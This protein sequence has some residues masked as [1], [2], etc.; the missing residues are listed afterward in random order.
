[1]TQDGLRRF[2]HG[3]CIGDPRKGKLLRCGGLWFRRSTRTAHAP[4]EL[5]SRG[6]CQSS[7][8]LCTNSSVLLLGRRWFH[9]CVCHLHLKKSEWM[10][11]SHSLKAI[12]DL[13]VIKYL[14]LMAVSL[15][16][17][18]NVISNGCDPDW[19]REVRASI[20]YTNKVVL[21]LPW[22]SSG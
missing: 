6:R 19:P 4:A 10:Q 14:Y 3:S 18:T 12:Y 5:R 11:L 2:S 1:M 22:L 21:G 15:A 8:L 17:I 13:N 20:I 16:C 9:I 7:G